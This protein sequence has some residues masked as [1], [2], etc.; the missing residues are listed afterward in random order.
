MMQLSAVG[1]MCG[2][3][4]LAAAVGE[5]GTLFLLLLSRV[6]IGLLKQ[7]LTVSRA[8]RAAKVEF[9]RLGRAGAGRSGTCRTSSI[10]VGAGELASAIAHARALPCVSF[11][12]R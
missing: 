5:G 7:S 6:P 10:D 9:G 1:G 12:F 8:A 11:G 2:Y 4:C 3:G